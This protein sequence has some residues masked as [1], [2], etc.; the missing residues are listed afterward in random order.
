MATHLNENFLEMLKYMD[1]AMRADK[2]A[3]HTWKYCNSTKKKAKGFEEARN[4][5]KYLINCVDGPQ[6]ALRM[7]GVPGKALSWYGSKGTIAWL[8]SNAQANAKKYFTITKIGDKTVQQLYNERKLCDG[9]ILTYVT[10]NHTNVYYGGAKSFDSGHAY[11]SGSGEGAPMNK[12]IGSLSCKNYKVGYILRIKDRAHYRVQ[13]GS[14]SIRENADALK[15]KLNKMGYGAE[16]KT[17]GDETKVQ[18][19]YFSGKT[20]AERFRDELIGK[21]ID[22]FVVEED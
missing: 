16:L 17:V 13:C 1:L 14:F 18:V 21:G 4:E 10:I 8:N 9:D 11:A 19:G 22:A 2:K 20:N 6:W 5:G 12:W 15:A 7:C 3:G